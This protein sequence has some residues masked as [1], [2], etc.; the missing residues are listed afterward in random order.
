MKD[1]FQTT[2]FMQ[3]EYTLLQEQVIHFRNLVSEIDI[4]KYDQTGYVS[5][6]NSIYYY[7]FID[8][9]EE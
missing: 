7:I 2:D 5:V 1:I 8:Q 4:S 9:E 6:V 3:N